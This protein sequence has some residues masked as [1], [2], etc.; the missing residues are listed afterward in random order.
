MLGVLVLWFG[1]GVEGAVGATMFMTGATGVDIE[2]NEI[3]SSSGSP[4][5]SN[6]CT[7]GV[8]SIDMDSGVS[9]S[10]AEASS[11]V[12]SGTVSDSF[13]GGVMGGLGGGEGLEA[14]IIF[15]AKDEQ[16]SAYLM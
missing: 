6:A 4:D 1:V 13:C 12:K 7:V 3:R 14:F 10:E 11:K 8:C 2:S 16:D 15:E 5:V 9:G